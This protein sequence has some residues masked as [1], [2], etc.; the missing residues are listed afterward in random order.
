VFSYE[1]GLV[2]QSTAT[3]GRVWQTK[4][5]EK[6]IRKIPK[7][8]QQQQSSVKRQRHHHQMSSGE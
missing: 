2:S 1:F 5:H 7:R 6:F 4:A 8:K 3:N